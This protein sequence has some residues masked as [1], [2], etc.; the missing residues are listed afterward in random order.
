VAA[1]ISDFDD[2]SFFQQDLPGFESL[3]FSTGFF[4]FL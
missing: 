2:G 1:Q 3:D 4:V